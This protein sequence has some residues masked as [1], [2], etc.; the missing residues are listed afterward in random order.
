MAKYTEEDIG[1]AISDVLNGGAIS[2]GQP[3]AMGYLPR[4]SGAGSA[5]ARPATT[6]PRRPAA[7]LFD[8]R[9]RAES[10]GY[11]ARRP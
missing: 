4:H 6:S 5:D 1:N 2:Q 9:A 8:T 11:C 3:A 7:G 10:R